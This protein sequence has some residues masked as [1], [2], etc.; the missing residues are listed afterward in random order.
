MGAGKPRRHRLTF[1]LLHKLSGQLMRFFTEIR[2]SGTDFLYFCV[3]S[4]HD[5][6]GFFLQKC[7]LPPWHV[8]YRPDLYKLFHKPRKGLYRYAR[9]R[10]VMTRAGG[11]VSGTCHTARTWTGTCNFF[12]GPMVFSL[13]E[14]WNFFFSSREMIQRPN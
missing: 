8:R 1:R 11:H 9:V 3:G 12:H 13:F 5:V 2:C 7:V 6:L 4:R 10:R 14:F